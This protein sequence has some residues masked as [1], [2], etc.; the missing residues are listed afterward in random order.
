MRIRLSV[1]KSSVVALGLLG[2]L[3]IQGGCAQTKD[4]EVWAPPTNVRWTDIAMTEERPPVNGYVRL[5]DSS[6]VG[7]FPSSVA[8]TRLSIQGSDTESG[9]R[10]PYIAPKPKNEFLMWNSAFDEQMAVSEVF[11]IAQRDLGGGKA[12]PRQ[13][14]AAFRA[15]HAKLGLVYATN[16]LTETETEMIGVLY[17]TDTVT[18]LAIFHARASSIPV[19]K[20]K[21][22]EPVNLWKHDSRALVRSKFETLVCTCMRE[23]VL[24][25]TPE[26]V[27]VPAGWVPAMPSYPVEW[28]PRNLRGG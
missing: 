15:L 24:A 3:T 9:I 11:P 17:E 12:V 13:I 19:A 21:R 20:E 14:V 8:V 2:A 16:Y 6:S 7:R 22:K 25:D 5:G 10:R 4:V 26:K 18:P 27:D 28:P 1:I 23:L